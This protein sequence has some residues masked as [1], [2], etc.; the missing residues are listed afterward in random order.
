MAMTTAMHTVMSCATPLRSGLNHCSCASSAQRRIFRARGRGESGPTVDVDALARRPICASPGLR[1]AKRPSGVFTS[2]FRRSDTMKMNDGFAVRRE[3]QEAKNEHGV[4]RY[5]LVRL[6]GDGGD[7]DHDMFDEVRTPDQIVASLNANRNMLFGARLHLEADASSDGGDHLSKYL[8]ACGPL[9]DIA[10]EDSGRQGEQI[11][12]LATLN[13]L[14]S[15]VAER[16]ERDGEGSEVLAELMRGESRSDAT[17]QSA[18][19]ESTLPAGKYASQQIR[20]ASTRS[21][22]KN[23]KGRAKAIE[24]VRAIATGLPRPGHSVVGAGT[25]K[26]GREGWVALAREYALLSA[27]DGMGSS[28]P[29]DVGIRR[30]EEVA[31]FASR[32]GEITGIEHLAHTSP[33]Y[34]REAGGAMARLFFV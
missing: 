13:G 24:A 27:A 3:L 34:L 2:P 9:L 1:Q 18:K 21:L 26:D 22:P 12:A 23:K 7:D 17:P 11:Q 30:S 33:E 15:W 16:L 6:S 19:K 10:R 32:E 20:D 31:L 25:Y 29:L 5:L 4:R 14:C 8:A 28:R